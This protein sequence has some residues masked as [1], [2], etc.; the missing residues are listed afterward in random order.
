MRKRKGD[1]LL[2]EVLE[3]KLKKI[4]KNAKKI[5]HAVEIFSKICYT[6]N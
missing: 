2:F 1:S 3:E 5:L 6:N 4:P